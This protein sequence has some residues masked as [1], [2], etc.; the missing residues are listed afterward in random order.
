MPLLR[1]H[2]PGL[3]APPAP[4]PPPALRG[5]TRRPAGCK[6]AREP[7]SKRGSSCLGA[8]SHRLDYVCSSKYAAGARA[9]ADAAARLGSGRGRAGATG[10]RKDRARRPSRCSPPCPRF[11]YRLVIGFF[12]AASLSRRDAEPGSDQ[13]G[14][15]PRHRRTARH[16]VPRT[17]QNLEETLILPTPAPQC[18]V[19]AAGAAVPELEPAHRAA[20]RHSDRGR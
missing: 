8:A 6:F 10:C 5:G 17:P 20:S 19:H 13:R 16:L 7:S 1:A 14:P 2:T 12:W 18:G 15:G 11:C 3:G 9:G 4:P